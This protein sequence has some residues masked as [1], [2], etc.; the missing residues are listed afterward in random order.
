MRRSVQSPV[1]L[2]ATLALTLALAGC[3]SDDSVDGSADPETA[4]V[5]EE[6]TQAAA[7]E[8]TEAATEEPAEAST[9]R[10][11]ELLDND[12]ISS[13]T[14]A[15][16]SQ[17]VATATPDGCDWDLTNVGGLSMVSVLIDASGASNFSL[18]RDVASGMF[19]DVTDVSIAGADNAFGYM[20]D[21]IVAMDIDGV[22]VQVMF[23]S[24]EVEVSGTSIV[25][26]LAQ[27]VANNL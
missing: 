2:L 17:A 26:D 5:T 13:I 4:E 23:V 21:V 12:S 25:A 10:A 9:T 16:F 1:V 15:D 7:E 14:G 20:G 6:A 27:E 3:G 22:L 18:T 8:I 19:D 11:C 24:F